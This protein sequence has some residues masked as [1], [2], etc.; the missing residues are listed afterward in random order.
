MRDLVTMND[1]E[2]TRLEVI[3]KLALK[4]LNHA[5]ASVMLN[6][7]IRQTKRLYSAYKLQGAKGITSKKRGKPSNNRISEGLKRTV[8]ALI[9]KH[10]YDFGPTLAC[11]KLQEVHHIDISL[12]SVRR[13]MIEDGLLVNQ[14]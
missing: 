14:I 8:L 7:S 9:K 11:E 13:I 12:G 2:I 1:I 6:L 10:Y 5:K 4:E 3:Q